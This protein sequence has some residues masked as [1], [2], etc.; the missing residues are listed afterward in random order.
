MTG[1]ATNPGTRAIDLSVEIAAPPEAVWEAISDGDRLASWFAPF[2][3][4]E[5][6]EGG[7]VTVA[8]EEGSEWPSRIAVWQPNRHLRLIDELPEDAAHTGAEMAL[9][10]RLEARDGTTVLHL[11]NSGLSAGE[12]W[13]EAFYMMTNGW[14]FFLWNLKH[15]VERHPGVSRTMISARPWVRGSREEVW[16]RLFGEQG[17]GVT[18]NG[19]RSASLEGVAASHGTDLSQR[20]HN[21][22]RFVLDG[23]KVLEGSVV[24]CDRPW[25]FAGMVA[26]LEDGVLHIE[27]EGSGE[28]WKLGVWLSAYGVEGMRCEE[29]GKALEKTVLRLFHEHHQKAL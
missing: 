14:R 16:D 4:V 3:S 11:V 19:P 9:D 23:G 6:G 10:Y 28:R 26:S 22:F 12:D 27:M 15:V 24:L 20:A 25:A 2:A 7:S 8:W 18:P 21:P 1:P 13:D 5:P 29:I 17:L